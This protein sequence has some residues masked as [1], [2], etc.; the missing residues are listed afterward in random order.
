M[1]D[2]VLRYPGDV[3]NFNKW[4]R[5]DVRKG[6]HV[7]RAGAGEGAGKDE[8]VMAAALYLPTSALRSQMSVTYDTTEF[9]GMMMEMAAQTI[10]KIASMNTGQ[11]IMEQAKAVGDTALGTLGQFTKDVDAGTMGEFVKRA[12]ASGLVGKFGTQIEAGPGQKVNPRTDILFSTQQFREWTFEYIMIPRTYDEAV[13]IGKIVNM[14]RFYMLPVYLNADAK[15]GPK[16][17]YM[18]GYP[19]E[20]TINLFGSDAYG[21]FQ[22]ETNTAA[23]GNVEPPQFDALRNANRIGRCVLKNLTVDQ[24]AGGKVAFVSKKGPKE[25]FPLVTSMTLDFQEVMLLGRDQRYMVGADDKAQFPDP[26]AE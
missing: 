22:L 2:T 25:L 21:P 4:L 15:L 5:F 9:S 1:A 18:M 14:F 6:R 13:A 10:E 17:A 7:G 11:N 8:V 19:Y 3:A 23:G 20:W 16:A 24:A 12:A 26:R